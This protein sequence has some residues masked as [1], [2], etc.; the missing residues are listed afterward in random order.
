MARPAEIDKIAQD[1]AK[2]EADL[3]K[4]Q[5][6]TPPG[7]DPVPEPVPA[8]KVD[9]TPA[10]VA[11]P[12]PVPADSPVAEPEPV[13]PEPEPAPEPAKPVDWEHKYNVLQGKYNKE[14]PRLA[15]SNRAV[16]DAILTLKAE[17]AKLISEITDLRKRVEDGIGK[18]PQAPAPA[19]DIDNDPD[20]QYL[21]AQY[22]D[23]ANGIVKLARAHSADVKKQID[24]LSTSFQEVQKE[25]IADK[26]DK[27]YDMLDAK[28]SNWEELNNTPDF[29]AWL[30]ETD[31]Y[32]GETRRVLIKRAYDRLD[33]KTAVNFF[34]DYL[35]RS[36]PGPTKPAVPAS[37]PAPNKPVDTRPPKATVQKI[38]H[39]PAGTEQKEI[40]TTAQ[41][42]A[43]YEDIRQGK[44]V[45][46]EE[47]RKR[48]EAEL[49]LAA[50]EGRIV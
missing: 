23:V 26:R 38:P 28:V 4:A 18:A 11:E 3:Y 31:R 48:L 25:K 46:R 44:F 9:P 22:P 27:F 41:V 17:N 30:D 13:T 19:A 33:G 5:G 40:I 49:D 6:V 16:N 32:S 50:I 34:E 1:V 7:P 39:R 20:V 21:K 45:G 29:N 36:A 37:R 43:F 15:E 42:T 12:E 14:I 8:A 47:E 24:T 35:D 2:L 10:P